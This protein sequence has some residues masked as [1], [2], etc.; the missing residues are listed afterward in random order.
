[1]VSNAS[2]DLPDPLK[3]V[4]TTS[5]SR[6]ISTS[7]FLRLCSRALLMMIDLLMESRIIPPAPVT[8][9]KLRI[10]CYH[11]CHADSGGLSD[12]GA[13]ANLGGCP[14][15]LDLDRI[16]AR[17]GRAADV[18]RHCRR[19]RSEQHAAELRPPS[20]VEKDH[21]VICAAHR[22]GTGPRCRSWHG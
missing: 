3:P 5:L 20:P 10:G 7:I 21:S 2:E 11:G 13:A 12:S 4:M 19:L 6:G 1:M 16:G 8:L 17:T 22:C 14:H 9:T 18:H 15:D